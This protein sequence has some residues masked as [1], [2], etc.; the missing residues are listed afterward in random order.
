[1]SRQLRIHY[2]GALYHVTSRGNAREKVFYGNK[3][4]EK[5]L[6]TLA[7]TVKRFGWHCH[8]YC[9]MTN[10]YHLLIE[11]PRANLSQGM[12][13]LNGMYTQYFNRSHKRVGHLFQGR[14]K[15][16]HVEKDRY[17]LE[18]S[19]YVVL[20]PVRAK[21]VENPE[22]WK[23]SSYR[24]TSGKGKA[25]EYLQTDWILSQFGGK[26]K[27]AQKRYRAFVREG[28]GVAT[29]PWEKV[30]GQVY[31]GSEDFIEEL[32]GRLKD[33]DLEEV[34]RAHTEVVKKGL[35]GLLKGGGTAAE[36]EAAREEGHT[37]RAIAEHLGVHYTAVTHRVRRKYNG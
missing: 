6:E 18:L 16:I 14:F 7:L 20:N 36:I 11:T 1:M 24:A 10:H 4:R 29:K 15:S 22:A 33:V 8:A 27:A 35:K 30:K 26:R 32:K 12:R 28:V 34:P 5:F 31:L 17:L 3:D 2:E 13:Q 37:M 23:W 9:L 25:E 21:M 19:R